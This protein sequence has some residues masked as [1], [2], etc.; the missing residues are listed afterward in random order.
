MIMAKLFANGRSQAVRLPKECRFNGREVCVARLDDIVI[1]Y[2]PGRGWAVM[3]GSLPQ[4]TDDF[5]AERSQPAKSQ[6]R[7]KL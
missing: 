7:K 3:E 5:M 1:L 6:R 4:F 2:P